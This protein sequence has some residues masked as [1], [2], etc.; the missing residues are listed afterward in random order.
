MGP[1]ALIREIFPVSS[2]SSA[3]RNSAEWCRTCMRGC[4][5][6]L[7]AEVDT[8][9]TKF[10]LGTRHVHPLPTRTAGLKL[11]L[12]KLLT[13]P[14][15]PSRPLL[16]SHCLH[17]SRLTPP[18]HHHRH[19][20]R[21]GSPP[22]PPA[23]GSNSPRLP[24]PALPPARPACRIPTESARRSALDPSHARPRSEPPGWV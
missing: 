7:A 18:R 4:S 21:P 20:P 1:L 3:N 11:C 13:H 5:P 8:S 23:P 22:L 9:A 19:R 24:N 10:H 2:E 12:V 6:V 15:N 14:N 17:L 16:S